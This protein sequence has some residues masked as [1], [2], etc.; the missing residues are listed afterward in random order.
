MTPTT[1][2]EYTPTPTPT[3]TPTTG[4]FPTAPV[5]SDQGVD[6][7]MPHP[8]TA[9][10]EQQTEGK[11]E[12]LLMALPHS[13]AITKATASSSE[14]VSDAAPTSH[15]PM[16]ANP[17]TIQ[18]WFNRLIGTSSL[19]SARSR[20]ATGPP[21]AIKT[22]PNTTILTSRF[23][24]EVNSGHPQVML[25]CTLTSPPPFSIFHR[26]IESVTIR[27]HVSRKS[28]P[29]KRYSEHYQIS[30]LPICTSSFT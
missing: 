25:Q 26:E 12:S 14:C 5:S 23:I 29:A 17:I 21:M 19:L 11:M 4:I 13:S 8:D 7:S 3:P 1:Q 18:L 10:V 20:F 27:K 2:L 22:L 15:M 24:K 30:L 16:K 6:T 9:P 28:S